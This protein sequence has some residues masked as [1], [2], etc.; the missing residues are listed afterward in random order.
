MAARF[1]LICRHVSNYSGG[2]GL[3]SQRP[4]SVLDLRS[5]HRAVKTRRNQGTWFADGKLIVEVCGQ[6]PDFTFC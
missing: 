5:Q 2:D 6:L 1:E 3:G 4:F